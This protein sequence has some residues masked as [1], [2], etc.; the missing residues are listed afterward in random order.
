MNRRNSTSLS[1]CCA[2]PTQELGPPL[3]NLQIPICGT[4][5]AAIPQRS[6]SQFFTLSVIA[7]NRDL[8]R[9]VSLRLPICSW[10]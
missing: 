4:H 3:D 1:S 6:K 2:S 5:T 7:L 10:N 8:E 9:A